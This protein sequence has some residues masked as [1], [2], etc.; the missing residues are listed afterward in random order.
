[1]NR[2]ALWSFDNMYSEEVCWTELR[3]H[4][5]DLRTLASELIFDGGTGSVRIAG[6]VFQPMEVRVSVHS[7]LCLINLLNISSTWTC[8]HVASKAGSG[9]YQRIRFMSTVKSIEVLDTFWLEERPVRP[10]SDMW[11]MW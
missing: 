11:N 4:R 1:M 8:E 10:K 5:N 7:C 9:K 6:N 3:F 2:V